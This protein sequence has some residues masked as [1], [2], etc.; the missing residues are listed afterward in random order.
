MAITSEY[1]RADVLR[2]GIILRS[3]VSATMITKNP[4]LAR[5]LSWDGK[6]YILN[7]ADGTYGAITVDDMHIV[8][9]FFD[10]ESSL[11]PYVSK[12]PHDIAAL[13]RGM[14]P[15]LRSIADNQTL[16]YNRQVYRG[17]LVSLITALFWSDGEYLSAALPWQQVFRN[18]A[19]IIRVELMEDTE[20]ALK[21]W[22][23]GS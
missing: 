4:D 1:P 13:F 23:G 15:Q 9:A 6:N 8:G 14:P 10:S 21:E 7:N 17:E 2:Q 22:Q 3:I 16:K 18:G 20:A 19:H 5:F 11:N 12:V